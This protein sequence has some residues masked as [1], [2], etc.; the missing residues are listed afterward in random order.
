MTTIQAR[1]DHVVGCCWF[2]VWALVGAALAF[3]LVSLGPI[4]LA[5]VWVVAALMASNDRIRDSAYGVLT[6]AG[7][8]SL[9]I[10][11]L[12]RDG[13]DLDPR[14]WLVIGIALVAAGVI[15]HTVRSHRTGA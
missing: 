6:G 12:H 1:I 15:G 14:P 9:F 8:V 2:W 7:L 13:S 3:G 10:A 4:L 5:P 11:H